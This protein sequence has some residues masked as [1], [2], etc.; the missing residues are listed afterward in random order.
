MG[1]NRTFPININLIIVTVYSGGMVCAYI[2]EN[3]L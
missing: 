2:V 1:L 3:A